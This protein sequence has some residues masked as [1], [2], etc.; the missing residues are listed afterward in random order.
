MKAFEIA[1]LSDGTTDSTIIEYQREG[2][3]LSLRARCKPEKTYKAYDLFQCFGLL[4]AD[5]STTK[6]LCKG[7]KINVY[8]SSMSSQMSAG[9]VAYELQLGRPAELEGV[10]RIF[11]Y[12]ENDITNNIQLQQEF[13]KRWIESL[14]NR[15]KNSCL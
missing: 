12:E 14:A 9:L 8:T 15:C 4:R 13:R 5:N 1:T 3:L 2:A 7:A 11:D 6:F 10:V